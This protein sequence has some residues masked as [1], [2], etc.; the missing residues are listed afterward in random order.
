MCNF[1]NDNKRPIMVKDK[2]AYWI[3]IADYDL[4][5]AEAMYQ[6]GR[7]LYVA[8]MCH[9]VIEKTLKAYWCGTQ[10]D[11]PPYTHN[12]MRLADGCGLYDKMS[13]EQK[14]FL[15]LVTNYNIE[16]RYPEDK[17]ALARTLTP[18]V[19]RQLIDDTK[20]LMTWIIEQLSAVTKP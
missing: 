1:A 4:K 13:D 17:E 19:C 20:Q 15:D 10:P 9:Q 2:V 16:A 8:F 18:Q 11:D 7:W 12:H 3:D 6:T 5:T 14:D